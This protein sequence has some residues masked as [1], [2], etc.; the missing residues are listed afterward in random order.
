MKIPRARNIQNLIILSVHFI[1]LL[2][3]DPLSLLMCCSCGSKNALLTTSLGLLL[4]NVI[5]WSELHAF[6]LTQ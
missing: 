1:L 6:L 2:H 3:P 5:H 4:P